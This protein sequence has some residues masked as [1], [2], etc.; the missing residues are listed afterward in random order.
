MGRRGRE[1]GGRAGPACFPSRESLPLLAIM[2]PLQQDFLP[3]KA[4]I[5]TTF[6]PIADLAAVE[7][8]ITPK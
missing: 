3:L 8:A 1:A 5:S 2:L 6:V 7:A 4:S